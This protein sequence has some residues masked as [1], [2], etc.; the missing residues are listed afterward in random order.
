LSPFFKVPLPSQFLHFC[1]FGPAGFCISSSPSRLAG[2]VR[3]D[4][5]A[6]TPATF[7]NP[8]TDPSGDVRHQAARSGSSIRALAGSGFPVERTYHVV[9]PDNHDS[10]GREPSVSIEERPPFFRSLFIQGRFSTSMLGPA[11]SIRMRM[12]RKQTPASM[13][14]MPVQ[15]VEIL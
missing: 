9:V 15:D 2:S 13:Q 8:P 6:P 11:R 4:R 12:D 14:P 7:A 5:F 10:V 3:H 1:F